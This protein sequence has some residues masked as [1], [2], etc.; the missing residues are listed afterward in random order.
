M[1]TLV[2]NFGRT[3]NYLRLSV[4][5]RCDLRCVYC[6][7][8]QMTFLPKQQVLSLE[9]LATIGETFIELGVKKIRITGGE[10]LI[11]RDILTL[12]ERLSQ[13]EQLEELTLT[14]NGTQLTQFAAPLAKMGIKRI[15]VSLDSLDAQQFAS[16][17]R[18]G[19]LDR[20]LQG[21]QAAIDC[22]IKVKINTVILKHYNFSAIDQLIDFVVSNKLD[23]SFIE[24]MPLGEISHHKRDEQFIDYRSLK[25]HVEGSHTLTPIVSTKTAGP[26]KLFS[27]NNSHS[28]IGF[29]TPHS[30]NFCAS[31]NRVRVTTEGRLLLCLGNEHSVDLKDILRRYPGDSQRLSQT[32]IDSLT[33]KP[34]KHHFD[35]A[36]P[37]QVLRFMNTTGG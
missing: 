10:P 21:I 32:I 9:E 36:E 3:I 20:V 37:V 29:I 17:T 31:C 18:V 6:M 25:S 24:E 14:T 13:H 28:H 7:D 33:I 23:I 27:I 35:L 11:R 22:G 4:T 19:E 26:A 16:I 12:L 5:D 8:E 34:E 30:D 15:N 2:D 1:S